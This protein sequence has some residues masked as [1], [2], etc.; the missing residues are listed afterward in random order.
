MPGLPIIAKALGADRG[1]ESVCYLCGK[2]LC[3]DLDHDH[4]PPKQLYAATVRQA[5]NPSDLLTIQ[6]HRNCNRSFQKD[7]D[8]FVHTLMPFARGSYAGDAIY[9]E[10][11]GKYRRGR[12]V[13]LVRKVLREFEPRPSGLVLPGNM[14]LKRQDGPRISR[15]AWK[16]VRGLYFKHHGTALPDNLTTWVSITPPDQVPPEHFL[17]FLS[18]PENKPRGQHPGVFDYRFQH[19][20]DDAASTQYWALL[21][22]DRIIITI[23]FD[24][25]GGPSPRYREPLTLNAA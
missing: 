23:L 10:I 8:Y 7:E 21:L 20:E 4:V 15:V 25:P 3:G 12:N 17:M 19:Y 14:V 16:I 1:T 22:W 24:D 18:S 9:A 2:S 5:N 6:V 13:P 11:L